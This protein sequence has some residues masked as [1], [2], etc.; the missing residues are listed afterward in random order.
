MKRSTQLIIAGVVIASAGLALSVRHLAAQSTP[1]PANSKTPKIVLSVSLISLTE[2][3]LPT[4]LAA[5]GSIAA[6]QEAIIGSELN[7]IR[8]KDIHAQ[9]GDYVR[10]GHV[11]ASFARD[12]LDADLAQAKAAL[13]EAQAN[14]LDAKSNADRVRALPDKG[15]VS[16][17]QAEQLLTQ[18][19]SAQARVQ[20]ATAALDQQAL[21]M[22]FSQVT[23]PDD[24]IISSRTATVGAVAQQGQELFKLI[25]QNRLE[26]RAEVTGQD[27]PTI[28]PDTPVS[29]ELEAGQR[30]NGKVRVVSPTID[31]Q[32]RNALV[33]VDLPKA[34]EQG[35]RPGLFAKGYFELGQRATPVIPQDAIALRDG[36]S[37]VFVIASNRQG[38]TAAVKQIK[39][40]TGRRIGN[41]VEVI[42]GLTATDQLVA[43]GVSFLNEGDHVKIIDAG[44][45]P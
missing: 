16:A 23:A 41:D 5:N 45:R 10:K 21:R 18:E 34:L 30:L 25:R 27:L 42:S 13:A 1:N 35:L 24:G 11:L 22:R 8:L 33:Y 31:P 43:S 28:K 15:A 4:R 36:L 38:Q 14:Y 29:I 40:Q 26:W 9:V 44:S 12:T 7:G 6:W 37:Y 32:S 3:K 39:I 19:K 17:Q 20:S 2:K